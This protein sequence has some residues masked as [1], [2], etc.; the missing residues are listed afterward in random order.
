VAIA[1]LDVERAAPARVCGAA[2]VAVISGITAAADPEA[3]IARFRAAID[4]SAA[5][6][7]RP[8]PALPRP[9]LR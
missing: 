8:G 6:P 9:T 1:G 2:G 7:N 4:R 5:P 3:A